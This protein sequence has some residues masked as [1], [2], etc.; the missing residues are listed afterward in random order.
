MENL[1]PV[2]DPYADCRTAIDWFEAGE[3]KV[4]VDWFKR[5]RAAGDDPE[6]ILE[7]MR[8]GYEIMQGV[9]AAD[10]EALKVMTEIRRQ[11]ELPSYLNYLR[12][13]LG[14]V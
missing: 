1:E 8:Q 11:I 14:H 5:A 10:P 13:R 6:F 12:A 9:L 3:A 7:V 4:G 2:S